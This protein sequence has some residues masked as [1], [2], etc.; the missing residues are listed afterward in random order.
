MKRPFAIAGLF[1]GLLLAALVLFFFWASTGRLSDDE[2]AQIKRYDAPAASAERDTFTVMTYN[3]GYLSG[4]TNNQPVVRPDTLF[5]NN[6]ER[7]LNLIRDVDPDILALQEV[8]YGGARSAHVHQLDTIA[9]RLGYHSAAQAVNWDERYLPFPYGGPS[10]HFGRTLSGQALLSKYPVRRHVRTVLPRPPQVFFRDAFYL[11]HL[12]QFSVV[13]IGGWPLVI[14]N[15]HLEA[16][17]VE[18]R[19]KQARKVVELY[20]NLARQNFP[21]IMLGDVNSVAPAAKPTLP[22]DQRP[23]FAGD[24]TIEMLLSGTGLSPIFSEAAYMSG[25]DINTFPSAAPNRKLDYILHEPILVVPVDREIRCGGAPPPSDHCAVVMSFMLP[26]PKKMLPD[27]RIPD[28][29]LPSLEQL[30]EQE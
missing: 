19:E 29:E 10:V 23:K 4:M 6:M 12:A 30:L 21:V 15:L 1:L 18:T 11:S 25:H 9:T 7:A 16:F 26:R 22:P 27:E 5:E 17:D 20:A 14:I 3:L 24:D 2:M 28:E 13:D 8:D